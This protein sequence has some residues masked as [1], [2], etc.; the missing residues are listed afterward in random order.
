MFQTQDMSSMEAKEARPKNDPEE[1]L[2]DRDADGR[3][4][5]ETSCP[6]Q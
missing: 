4:K 1:D 5:P 6:T 3:P 2:S